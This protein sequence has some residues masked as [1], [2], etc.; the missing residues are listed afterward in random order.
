MWS[1]GSG[2]GITVDFTGGRAP[3]PAGF[4]CATRVP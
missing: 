1:S 2:I 4:Y 3:E